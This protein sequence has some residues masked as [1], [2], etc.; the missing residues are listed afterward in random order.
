MVSVTV[1]SVLPVV[2]PVARCVAGVPCRTPLSPTVGLACLHEPL[3][4][5]RVLCSAR[6]KHF[7]GPTPMTDKCS[8]M[9][10]TD[11]DEEDRDGVA[12]SNH[13]SDGDGDGD[14]DGESDDSKAAVADGVAKGAAEGVAEGAVAGNMNAIAEGFSV[15]AGMAHN[16]EDGESIG[17]ALVL[18]KAM[19]TV[20]L[21]LTAMAVPLLMP[22]LKAFR[23]GITE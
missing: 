23:E 5:D 20:W 19:E 18:A 6:Y 15:M 3:S 7:P 8:G 13:D 14:G 10:V 12:D 21:L 9:S 11:I 16:N 22:C 1:P 2:L 17:M 4:E